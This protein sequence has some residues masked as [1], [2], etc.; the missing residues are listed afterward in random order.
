M[1][2]FHNN[3]LI[4]AGGGAAAAAA[5]GSDSFAAFQRQVIRHISIAPRH[6]VEIAEHLPWSCWVKRSKPVPEQITGQELFWLEIQL[7][8]NGFCRL[9]NPMI[10]CHSRQT[11]A[12]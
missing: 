5:A 2:V 6:Q 9:A 7:L 10:H 1:S 11:K 4:G 3:A 8:C 12:E